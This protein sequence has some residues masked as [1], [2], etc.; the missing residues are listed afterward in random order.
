MRLCRSRSWLSCNLGS[1][2]HNGELLK[3]HTVEEVSI[4]WLVTVKKYLT[5][6]TSSHEEIC[7]DKNADWV[8]YTG[9]L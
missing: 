4:C 7:R 3:W 6:L 9:D 2:R 1:D 8:V 5:R